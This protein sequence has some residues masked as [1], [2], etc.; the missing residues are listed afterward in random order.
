MLSIYLRLSLTLCFCSFVTGQMFI[1]DL[2]MAGGSPGFTA[3]FNLDKYSSNLFLI[4][5]QSDFSFVS[6]PKHSER[7]FEGLTFLHNK[8]ISI[9]GY[10]NDM[11]QAMGYNV[12]LVFSRG[13]NKLN[14]LLLY[15]VLGKVSKNDVISLSYNSLND[16][17]SFINV[18]YA[19]KTIEKKIF[20]LELYPTDG[21]ITF[22]AIPI[23]KQSSHINREI[24]SHVKYN[25]WG[26]ILNNIY[27]NHTLLYKTTSYARISSH[28]TRVLIPHE[29]YSLITSIVFGTL[30]NNNHCQLHE[31]YNNSSYIR[32]YCTSIMDLPEFYF[33]IKDT[34]TFRG[35][36]VYVNMSI[37]DLFWEYDG[38]CTFLM[39]KNMNNRDEFEFSSMFLMKFATIFDFE[40]K[41]IQ[42]NTKFSKDVLNV[43]EMKTI[44]DYLIE[45]NDY[46]NL[47]FHLV[48][49]TSVLLFIIS[50]VLFTLTKSTC[51]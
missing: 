44:V 24:I 9:D 6:Q 42:F 46:V 4:D 3:K 39:E 32:C 29:M 31:L 38:F 11:K 30:I 25:K 33:G 22:G 36:Y 13:G 40:N 26:V 43:T 20:L 21:Q 5:L 49:L 16:E 27:F 7:D 48:N 2:M 18:L 37:Y 28:D 15:Y 23:N 14:D 51:K 41:L 47:K 34:S 12:N 10:D 35:K 45:D 50:I 19:N 8:T 17:H 1:Q